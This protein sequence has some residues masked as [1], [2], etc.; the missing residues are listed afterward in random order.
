M[1]NVRTV[2]FGGPNGPLIQGELAHKLRDGRGVVDVS[3]SGQD[4]EL[5]IG[6]LL[7]KKGTTEE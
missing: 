2:Q 7:P 3:A 1:K 5:R 4:N 6:R